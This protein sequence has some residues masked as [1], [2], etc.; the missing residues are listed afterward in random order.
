MKPIAAVA[1]IAAIAALF[2]VYL[3][4]TPEPAAPAPTEASA[5]TPTSSP[6]S[7]GDTP[8]PTAGGRDELPETLALLTDNWLT[9]WSVRSIDLNELD[10]GIRVRDPRD[11]IP[12]IDEPDFI[13]VAEAG[14][15][16]DDREPGIALTVGD[17]SR[18][19]PLSILTRHEI[20]NDSIEGRPVAV[21]FCPL[22]NTGIAFD[23]V[24]DGTTFRFGV[25][26]LLR[27][28]DLVMWDD[29][30]QS[31]WQ[32]ITGE[33]IVGDLTGTRL[34]ILP[35]PVVSWGDF[36]AG[37]PDGEL[38][39]QNQGFGIQYGLNPY[40]GYS[41]SARPFLFSGEIDDRFPALE[42]VVGVTIG[43]ESKAYPFSVISSERAVNDTVGGTPIVVLWGSPETADALD[44]RV[45]ADSQA[46]GS[47]VAYNRTVDGQVLTFAPLGD[48]TFADAETN[49]EWNMLGQ[50]VSGPLTGSRLDPV[51]HR[52]EFWF[53]WQAFF[54]DAAVYGQ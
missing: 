52:N 15:W 21:T 12:P 19:Y 11:R 45:V 22:C 17:T 29:Q 6:V 23:R 39:S 38:L 1:G 50:A 31:L 5:T 49:S 8:L 16:P 10:I 54:P 20:V 24:I 51:P 25:S 40:V 36:K 44:G 7:S 28:S 3:N 53:A 48:S 43:D 13:P 18:F 34:P 32:Q 30:T 4:R 2:V 14:D 42:R 27:N 47:G 26:G 35:A 41:T 9:N 37:F 33:A 46:I